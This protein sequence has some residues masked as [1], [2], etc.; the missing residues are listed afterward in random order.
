M[1][2]YVCFSIFHRTHLEGLSL[3]PFGRV[4][5]PRGVH[6]R[7]ADDFRSA[8]NA[9][10]QL[11]NGSTTITTVP[12]L[13][14]LHALVKKCQALLCHTSR[15]SMVLALRGLQAPRSPEVGTS[16]TQSWCNQDATFGNQV[17]GV[18]TG[19]LWV[20]CMHWVQKVVCVLSSCLDRNKQVHVCI[21][22]RGYDASEK[23]KDLL[24]IQEFTCL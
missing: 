14:H 18:I 10:T 12:L 21:L 23:N 11:A 16:W 15:K 9:A 20:D 6:L 3:S 4:I 5:V 22:A 2:C 19:S 8:L 7:N 24:L 13:H 1:L 17:D